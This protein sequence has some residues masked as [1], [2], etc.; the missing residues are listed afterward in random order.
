M[1]VEGLRTDLIL[2]SLIVRTVHFDAHR[3][4]GGKLPLTLLR[5]FLWAASHLLLTFLRAVLAQ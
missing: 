3:L 5:A 1:V 2:A 4:F